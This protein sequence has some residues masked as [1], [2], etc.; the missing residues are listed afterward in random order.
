M[1]RLVES[2]NNSHGR[3]GARSSGLLSGSAGVPPALVGRLQSPGRARCP[4]SPSRAA[5]ARCLALTT[6]CILVLAACS[7]GTYPVD[8]FAEMHY[9]QSQK[10]LEPDRLAPPP[11]AVPVTGRS[12][13]ITFEQAGSLQSPFA[14]NPQ[15]LDR[16]R[17]VFR[18]NCAMCHGADGRG[19]SFIAQRFSQSQ[20]V[21]PVDFTGDRA[22]GRSDGELYWIVTYGLGNMPRFANML[23]DDDRWAVVQAVRSLQ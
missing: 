20:A 7:P 5:A 22:R 21:P 19:T 11:D 4:H 23:T 10:L 2:G 8:L 14:R 15:T 3:G 12:A 13:A 9:Q 1:R 6:L 18:V 17:Q 16:G